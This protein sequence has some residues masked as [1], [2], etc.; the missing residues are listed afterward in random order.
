MTDRRY[1]LFG[2]EVDS[3]L[4]LDGLAE[5][6]ADGP[7]ELLLRLAPRAAVEAAFSGPCEPRAASETLIDGAAYVVER[8][9][10]G[11]LRLSWGDARFHLDAGAGELRCAPEDP[12]AA[13]WRRLLLDSVLAAAAMERGADMLHAGAVAVA[14]ADGAVA[15]M[16]STGGGKSTLTAELVRRGHTLVTDDLLL[17]RSG[18]DGP[19]AVPG[20]PLMNLPASDP[21][22]E[23]I[24]RTLAELGDERWVAVA[25]AVA[26]PRPLAA[27]VLLDRGSLD[28]GVELDAL[29][30]P[31]LVLMANALRSGAGADRRA[32]RFETIA[33]VAAAVPALHLRAAADVAPAALAETLERELS[34][35]L[36]AA[37]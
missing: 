20:P 15:L 32:R 19:V 9:R 16:A 34:G 21:H 17:V 25:R 18:P 24:G 36:G 10:D 14:A 29:P 23:E 13:G 1:R 4:E 3:A 7:P 26:E 11:D 35:P 12:A 8:G 22:P 5:S 33:D 2:L 6:A 27:V 31:H 37:R 30:S 28:A